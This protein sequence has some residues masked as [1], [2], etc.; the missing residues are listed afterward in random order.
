MARSAERRNKSRPLRAAG[1][2]T[3]GEGA[4][5][6]YQLFTLLHTGEEITAYIDTNPYELITWL[7]GNAEHWRMMHPESFHKWR[8]ATWIDGQQVSE[9]DFQDWSKEDFVNAGYP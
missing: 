1:R 7:G 3:V 8:V 5:K 4:I 2:W 9:K 6:I